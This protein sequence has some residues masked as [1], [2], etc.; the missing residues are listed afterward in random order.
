MLQAPCL[1]AHFVARSIFISPSLPPKPARSTRPFGPVR[2]TRA[3]A[4]TS[5]FQRHRRPLR[6][7]RRVVHR[8]LP[9]SSACEEPNQSVVMPPSL[10]SLNRRRPISSSPFNSFDTDEEYNS[11]AI[12]RLPNHIKCTPA[13]ASPHS[14][15]P[16]F[17][18]LR[19]P[20]H[21]TPSTTIVV[22]S[23]SPPAPPRHCP[24]HQSPR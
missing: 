20:S 11:T 9:P 14:L 6:P 10:P 22:S 5:G 12:G 16:S 21:P 17:A 2:P 4:P 1:S 3:L 24:G 23:S 7:R 13:S 15:L 19:V 18:L 8:R